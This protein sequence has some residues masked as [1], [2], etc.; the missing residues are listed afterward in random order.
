[1]RPCLA[2]FRKLE[3][4]VEIAKRCNVEL[5]LNQIFLPNFPILAIRTVAPILLRAKPREGLRRAQSQLS[6]QW[7]EQ[8][9]LLKKQVYDDRLTLE[10]TVINSMGFA[11][12][13]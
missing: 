8:N 6:R 1:M 13:F 9:W 7:P 5:P 12:F 10:L 4:K 3:N 11:G 2:I